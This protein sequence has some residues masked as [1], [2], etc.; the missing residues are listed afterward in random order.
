MYLGSGL[1]NQ[2]WASVVTRIIAEKLGY[3]Y[4]IKGKELWKGAGWMPYFWGE[5]VIGGSGPDGGPPESLPEGIQYYYKELQGHQHTCPHDINPLDAGLFFVPDNT[6]LDGCFQNMLYIEDRRDD[7]REW[8]KVDEDKV[9]RDYSQDD[10]CVIHFR[11]GDY[12]TGHSF[13][14]PQ[15]YQMAIAKMKEKR[16][17]MRFVI[18]TDDPDLARRHIPGV[19]VIGAAISDEPGG[20]DYKIGWYQ[21][22]GGPISIDYSIILTAKNLIVSASTF[23]FWPA[24]LS[25]DSINVIA[26]MHWFDWNISDGWWRPVDSIVYDWEYLD[27]GGNLKTGEDCWKE[28]RRYSRLINPDTSGVVVEYG[29]N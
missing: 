25:V 28:Y 15:Y 29:Q 12:S 5:E 4:G 8:C 27:R 13:L 24:W 23:A 16:S 26:P 6:K 22:K 11:G 14:P 18:V 2:I 21:M 1:G 7:I 17:D 3:K 20:P 19:E 10:V 9:V